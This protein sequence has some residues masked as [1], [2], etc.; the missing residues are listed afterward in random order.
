MLDLIKKSRS[1]RNFDRSVEVSKKDL[2]YL[3]EC[4]RNTPAGS[5]RQPFKYLLSNDD[6]TNNI[7][8]SKIY[9]A[10]ALPEKH[11][12]Y[13]GNEPPAYITIFQKNDELNIN[14]IELGIVAQTICLAACDKGFATCMIANFKPSELKTAL[15]LNKDFTPTLV[16]AIG[17]SKETIKLV[18]VPEGS[19]FN[20]YRDESDVHYVPKTRLKDLIL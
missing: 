14:K 10:A 15:N 2:E 9:F 20:Y 7:I 11:F 13:K 12:P 3:I 5:N 19:N 6:K 1:T 18:D 8:L 17:K 16:I 4:A